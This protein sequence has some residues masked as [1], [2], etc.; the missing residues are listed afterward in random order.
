MSINHHLSQTCFQ[1]SPEMLK[2]LGVEWSIIGHSER[3]NLFG[4]DDKVS[5]LL[6]SRLQY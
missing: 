3:R 4:E 2:D 1:Y 6:L 5:L